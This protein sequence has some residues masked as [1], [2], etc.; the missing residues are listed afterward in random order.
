M[1]EL[2]LT[3]TPP[4]HATC[5][6]RVPIFSSLDG[7]QQLKVASFATPVKLERGDLLYRAGARMGQLFVVHTG[8]LKLEHITAS[9]RLQLVRVAGPGDVVG[10]HAFLTGARPEVQAEALTDAQ[11]CV[12]SHAD[13]AKLIASYPSI[14]SAMLR[15]LSERVV[16]AERRL[17]LGSMDVGVR[18]ASYLLDLPGETTGEGYKV[19]LPMPKKDLASYLGTTP[20]SFSRALGRLQRS[21]LVAVDGDVIELLDLD[22]LDALATGA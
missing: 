16:D 2:P 13:L 4:P 8:Q 20:E 6:Q 1:R 15:S 21:G 17:G 12:F 18:V 22:R 19:R 10:E 5:V 14:A 7:E 9:G 3:Q 11:M